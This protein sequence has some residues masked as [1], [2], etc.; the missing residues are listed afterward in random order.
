MYPIFPRY[1]CSRFIS[2]P[3]KKVAILGTFLQAAN[4][5]EVPSISHLAAIDCDELVILFD[6][7]KHLINRKSQELLL[8]LLGFLY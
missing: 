1:V 5:V 4:A 8:K 2:E 3:K 7:H 6:A